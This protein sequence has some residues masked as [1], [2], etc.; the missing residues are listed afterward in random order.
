MQNF[1]ASADL[2]AIG[3][4]HHWDLIA[5]MSARSIGGGRIYDALIAAS[6][7]AAGANVILTWNVKDFLAVAP[8]GLEVRQP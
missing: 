4:Q 2:V 5:G 8:H 3:P 7:L 6:T 1:G